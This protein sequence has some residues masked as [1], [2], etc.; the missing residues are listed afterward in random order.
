MYQDQNPALAEQR[1]AVERETVLRLLALRQ[2]VRV[3]DVGC[4]VGRWALHLAPHVASYLGID[5][6]AALITIARERVLGLWQPERF[7]FQELPAAALGT[8]PL[9]VPPPF[10]LVI[11]AGVLVYVNDADCV[12]VLSAI[13]ELC[14]RDATVY[15]REPVAREQRLTLDQFFSSELRARYSAVYRTRAQY[16]ALFA[17]T[18]ASRRFTLAHAGDLFGDD[19]GNRAETRQQIFLWRRTAG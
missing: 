6:S 4:G 16:D 17:P 14:E 19:L 9:H 2:P 12:R 8:A 11:V 15:V 7:T 3:L 18:L 13:A 5:F 10:D 1:D